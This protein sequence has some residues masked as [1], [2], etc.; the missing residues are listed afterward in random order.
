MQI[1]PAEIPATNPQTEDELLADYDRAS[2]RERLRGHAMTE[3]TTTAA[4][5]IGQYFIGLN[6]YMFRSGKPARIEGIVAMRGR[7]CFHLKWPD[8]VQDWSP[9]TDEDFS[10]SG[11][12]GLF[13]EIM[14]ECADGQ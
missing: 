6:P 12:R 13:Y 8:G 2:I 3:Q 9:V 10:G 14:K 4:E 7:D 11:G 5:F 1:V